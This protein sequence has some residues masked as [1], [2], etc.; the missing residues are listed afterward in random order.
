MKTCNLAILLL[1]MSL[2]AV[3][4]GSSA[5]AGWNISPAI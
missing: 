4:W 5:R 1:G 3:A 2:A